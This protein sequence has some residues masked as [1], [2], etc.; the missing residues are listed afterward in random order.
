LRQ[1]VPA[2]DQQVCIILKIKIGD[3]LFPF[4]MW[5]DIELSVGQVIQVLRTL[6]TERKEFIMWRLC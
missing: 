4:Y 5:F 3:E 6:C 1:F 2:L